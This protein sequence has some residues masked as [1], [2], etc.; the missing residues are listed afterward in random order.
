MGAD[1]EIFPIFFKTIIRTVLSIRQML[2]HDLQNTIPSCP[3]ALSSEHQ[4]NWLIH[5]SVCVFVRLFLQMSMSRS[6]Q[7]KAARDWVQRLGNRI[8][9]L[10]QVLTSWSL[11]ITPLAAPVVVSYLQACSRMPTGFGYLFTKP[12][13]GV[14]IIVSLYNICQGECST[15]A[16]LKSCLQQK[17]MVCTC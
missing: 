15:L 8:P 16:P 2:V 13:A 11:I 10:K 6:W 1:L 14:V 12:A 5:H 3:D 7:S 17:F 4:A 9:V